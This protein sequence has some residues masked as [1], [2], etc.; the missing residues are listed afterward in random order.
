MSYKM[1]L[2]IALVI[3]VALS[4]T[5]EYLCLFANIPETYSLP[6]GLIEVCHFAMKPDRCCF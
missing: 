5:A 2:A 3:E 1:N 4:E 6:M